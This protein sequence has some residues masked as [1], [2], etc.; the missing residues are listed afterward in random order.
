MVKLSDGRTL[1]ARVLGADPDTH[2]AP[3]K[4]DGHAGLPVAPIGDSATLR[5]GEWACAIGNPLGDSRF[6]PRQNTSLPS[7]RQC[8]M[9]W[10]PSFDNR[11]FPSP[12]SAED[13]LKGR[14]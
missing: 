1:R 14:T 9:A 3:I 2:I 13:D 11:H 12:V 6:S 5:M 10:T 7:A 8:S 4:V